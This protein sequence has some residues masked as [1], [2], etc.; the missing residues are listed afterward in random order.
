M[1]RFEI[2]EYLKHIV[3]FYKLEAMEEAAI[4][5]AINRIDDLYMISGVLDAICDEEGTCYGHDYAVN[6]AHHYAEEH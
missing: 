2:V 5:K 1:D 6:K 4:I 3:Q